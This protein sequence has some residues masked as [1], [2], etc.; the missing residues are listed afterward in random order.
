MTRYWRASPGANLI[1]S[2]DS[3]GVLFRMAMTRYVSREALE[4]STD[5]WPQS[6]GAPRR[7]AGAIN[8]LRF[9][10]TDCG[11]SLMIVL[12]VRCAAGFSRCKRMDGKK[13]APERGGAKCAPPAAAAAKKKS[14]RF[15]AGPGWGRSLPRRSRERKGTPL[16]LTRSPL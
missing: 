4:L 16:G 8:S 3:S 15:E 2:I 11:E 10:R 1:P 7:G 5:R 6:V 13:Q 14:P 12:I 9:D